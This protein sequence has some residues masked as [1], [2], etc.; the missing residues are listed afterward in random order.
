MQAADEAIAQ[1]VGAVGSSD[2]QG[3]CPDVPGREAEAIDLYRTN[4][5]K[6]IGNWTWEAAIAGDLM[7][8]HGL[9]HP[10]MDKVRPLSPKVSK[11]SWRFVGVGRREG[12]S[13]IEAGLRRA[14][15]SVGVRSR[16][17]A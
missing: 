10:T 13:E 6:T 17:S 1:R 2:Q 5:G 14:A 4:I 8:A 7:T 15:R 16:R 12:A 9:H 11:K 3:P